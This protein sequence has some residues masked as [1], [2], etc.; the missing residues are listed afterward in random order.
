MKSFVNHIDMP[1]KRK[2]IK[3]LMVSLCLLRVWMKTTFLIFF[4]NAYYGHYLLLQPGKKE[5]E[6]I[7]TLNR[8]NLFT[9][10]IRGLLGKKF[11]LISLSL[12]LCFDYITPAHFSPNW[13]GVYANS[14]YLVDSRYSIRFLYRTELKATKTPF[15]SICCSNLI[16]FH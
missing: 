13:F 5:I 12:H 1:A 8:N 7:N 10:W 15:L 2:E 16:I 9:N 4:Q 3:V 11:I 6:P 14:Q